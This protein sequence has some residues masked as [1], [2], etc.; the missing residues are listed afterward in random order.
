MLQEDITRAIVDKLKVSLVEHLRPDRRQTKSKSAYHHYLKG[1]FY[2]SK[3]YEG[4]LRTAR[5]EFE[6][7][8][9]DDPEYAL[10]V[11]R[12]RGHARAQGPVLAGT[13]TGR[14]RPG[15]KARRKALSIESRVAEAHTSLALILFERILG[16]D[17]G[18][19]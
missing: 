19:E 18:R 2:W 15:G 4:G 3:R 7:A 1:R 10:A 5:E 11:L 13:P 6:R 9:A 16:L 14:V 12:A 17:R 8:I